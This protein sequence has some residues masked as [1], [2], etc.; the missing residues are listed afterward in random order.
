MPLFSIAVVIPDADFTV[1][2]TRAPKLRAGDA[3]TQNDIIAVGGA[4]DVSS[5]VA[6]RVAPWLSGYPGVSGGNVNI[7]N[8]DR[9]DHISKN[10]SS[11][12]VGNSHNQIFPANHSH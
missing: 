6:L 3:V 2:S 11:I 8:V 12:Y 5:N 10:S 9:S 7:S 1:V 4:V